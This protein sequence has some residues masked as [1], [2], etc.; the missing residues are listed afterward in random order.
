MKQDA[1]VQVCSQHGASRYRKWQ[2]TA[3]APFLMASILLFVSLGVFSVGRKNLHEH[4]HDSTG[5]RDTLPHHHRRLLAE[6]KKPRILYIVTTLAEYNTGTR[7]TIRGSDRLQETL[8]PVVAEGTRSMIKAGY[9][10]DVFLVCHFD[11]LP[12]RA[13]LIESKLPKGVT[14]FSWSDATPLGYDTGASTFTKLEN[15]TLHLSR[16]HRFVIKDH[17]SEYDIFVCFED[18]MLITA[19]HV[20]HYVAVT[21]ELERLYELAPEDLPETRSH[22][23]ATQHYHGVMTKAQL[24]RTIPGWMRVEVLLDEEQYG[25]QADTGPVPV[26]LMFG[27]E[28][29]HVDPS[30]CCH[31]S[32]D[33]VTDRRPAAPADDKLVLWETNIMPLGVRKLPNDSWLQWAVTQRGPNQNQLNVTQVIGDYWTN[34]KKDFYGKESRP[35]GTSFRY[36]NNQGG[37][38]ATRKQLWRW[39]TEICPGGFLP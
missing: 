24:A 27:N 35:L 39:H 15:R 22:Q 28:Q 18:D 7:A 29:Q 19:N 13:A 9:H 10:V 3:A 17:I 14:L 30:I 20:Q 8:I 11:L 36:I 21:E 16:Q 38:M 23:E 37:W 4:K 34:R 25:A 2:L 12:E 31:V 26:D 1:A 5:I 6:R 32:H 33:H